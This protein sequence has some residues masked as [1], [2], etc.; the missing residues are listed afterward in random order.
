MRATVVA[1]D[2]KKPLVVED[3]QVAPPQ[4]GEVRIK[5]LST[6]LCPTDSYTWSGKVRHPPPILLAMRFLE[7]RFQWPRLPR[8]CSQ[9]WHC[10]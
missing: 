8:A 2:V 6:A 7:S 5:I 10:C 3:V 9:H 1:Y 4:A